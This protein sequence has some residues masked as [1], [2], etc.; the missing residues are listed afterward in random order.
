MRISR[1][2]MKPYAATVLI[3]EGSSFEV[4]LEMSEEGVRKWGTIEA[5]RADL[6]KRYA[7]AA[8][9]RG[10]RVNIDTSHWRD[11]GNS[12]IRVVE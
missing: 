4:A 7:D 6:A 8:R 11:V 12:G 9:E 3:K 2:W 1:S 10:V 5:L